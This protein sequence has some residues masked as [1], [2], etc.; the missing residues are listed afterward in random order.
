MFDLNEDPYETVNLAFQHSYLEKRKEL[1][2]ELAD[3]IDRTDDDYVL[4][5]L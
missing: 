3:W 1:Q 2:T 5:E 4:P